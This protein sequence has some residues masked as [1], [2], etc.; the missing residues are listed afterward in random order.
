MSYFMAVS[1]KGSQKLLRILVNVVSLG[2]LLPT[3]LKESELYPLRKGL[4]D[5][6]Q[7]APENEWL[8]S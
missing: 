7:G 8:E 4:R 2:S 5:C 3:Y 1:W 6:V